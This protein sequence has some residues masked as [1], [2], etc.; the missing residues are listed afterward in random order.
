MEDRRFEKSRAGVHTVEREDMEVRVEIDRT[1]EALQKRD[2]AA[3][4]FGQPMASCLTS[5]PG[6][7]RAEE[8]G[9]DLAGDAAV[10]GHAVAERERE[11]ENPLA[12]RDPGQHVIHEVG[13]SVGHATAAARRAK[14]SSLA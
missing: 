12:N 3:L 10:K 4:G 11:R 6:E 1:S 2:G 13:G 14:T 8:H 5:K 9:A 7:E